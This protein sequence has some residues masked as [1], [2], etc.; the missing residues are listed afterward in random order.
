MALQILAI[1]GYTSCKHNYNFDY[2]PNK[3]RKEKIAD[4]KAIRGPGNKEIGQGL[5]EYGMIIFLVAIV[6]IA[7]L[8]LMGPQIGNMFSQVTNSF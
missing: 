1:E 7:I 6:V 8:I 5:V 2:T 3:Y 4:M